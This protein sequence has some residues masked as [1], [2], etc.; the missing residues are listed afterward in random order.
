VKLLIE[1]ANQHQIILEY[2][3]NDF[4]LINKPKIKILLQKYEK[5]KEN[6]KKVNK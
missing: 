4:Y 6:R 3:K 1:Y 2:D 5:E